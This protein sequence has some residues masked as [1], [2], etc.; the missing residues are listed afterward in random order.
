MTQGPNR[1]RLDTYLEGVEGALPDLEQALT[2]WFAVHDRLQ[3]T[4][5]NLR[6][7]SGSLGD[8]FGDESRVAASGTAAF[9]TSAESLETKADDVYDGYTKLT[10]VQSRLQQ[11]LADRKTMD[12]R[13]AGAPDPGAAPKPEDYKKL[14]SPASSGHGAFQAD[15]N[16]WR[17]QQ[18]NHEAAFNEAETKAAHHIRMLDGAFTDASAALR[19][20][21][22]KTQ[23]PASGSDG[24]TQ[25]G[26][27]TTMPVY[28]PTSPGTSSRRRT[29]TAT[30]AE[31]APTG[32]HTDPYADGGPPPVGAPSPHPQPG[33]AYADPGHAAD[34]GPAD[35]P[36]DDGWL[37]GGDHPYT[38][39]PTTPAGAAPT[40]GPGPVAGGAGSPATGAGVAAASAAGGAAGLAAG[41]IRA[42]SAAGRAGAAL[43][44]TEAGAIGTGDRAAGAGLT[45]RAGASGAGARA[46][47]AA[48]RTGAGGGR[49]GARSG[50]ARSGGARSGGGAGGRGGRKR[51]EREGRERDLWDDGEDWLD[52]EATGPSVLE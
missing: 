6:K 35:G 51:D 39:T 23:T 24:R 3:R 42:A 15:Y 50:S 2:D 47:A 10:V 21:H 4:A 16:A 43:P 25:S 18:S 44:A 40:T 41:A 5:S 30:P 49:A 9:K 45:G 32:G 26:G 37:A 20:I 36:P 1:A 17:T 27:G 52:D 7:Q 34:P 14:G 33:P 29:S 38:A 12:A 13:L 22:G 48:G 28:A 46:G 31:A 8:A 19:R 11:A